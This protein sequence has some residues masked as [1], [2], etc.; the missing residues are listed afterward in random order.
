MTEIRWIQISD[1]HCQQKNMEEIPQSDI[2]LINQI[3]ALLPQHPE[4]TVYYDFGAYEVRVYDASKTYKERT[5][6]CTYL[7][8]KLLSFLQ[9]YKTT[10]AIK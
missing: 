1:R 2:D 9:N 10:A 3:K 8:E 4:L 6:F 5:I 7:E